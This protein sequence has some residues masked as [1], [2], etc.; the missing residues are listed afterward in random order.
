MKTPEPDVSLEKSVRDAT[1]AMT[2]LRDSDGAMVALALKFAR[3]IDRDP[4][5]GQWSAQSLIG[6]LKSL[7]GSPAERRALG[8]E[9]VVSGR[10]AEL[11][12]A[13]AKR[14]PGGNGSAVAD[15]ATG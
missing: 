9:E 10:L 14:R 4:E 7:G 3:D 1:R 2:W 5:G 11:R 12:A 13:R 8:V 15:P 6:C